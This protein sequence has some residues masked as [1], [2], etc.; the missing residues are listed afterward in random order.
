MKAQPNE[1]THFTLADFDVTE[2][3]ATQQ[4]LVDG[5]AGGPFYQLGYDI[6]Y[7]LWG[8]GLLHNL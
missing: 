8:P 6:A 5:G 4:Q 1:N 3:N 7:L 2:L